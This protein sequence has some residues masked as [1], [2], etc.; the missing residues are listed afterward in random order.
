MNEQFRYEIIIPAAQGDQH[1]KLVHKVL[2]AIPETNGLLRTTIQAIDMGYAHGLRI[3]IE[4]NG[5]ISRSGVRKLQDIAELFCTDGQD[6]LEGA[7]VRCESL[8]HYQKRKQ[9][10]ARWEVMNALRMESMDLSAAADA[11]AN[12]H[13]IETDIE[14]PF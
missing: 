11:L 9:K 12:S 3:A 4:C 6:Y 10:Q 8:Q 5:E 13:S 2:K 7:E 1:T 14:V